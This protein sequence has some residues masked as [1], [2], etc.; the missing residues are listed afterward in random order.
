MRNDPSG[1]VAIELAA[2]MADREPPPPG[3]LLAHMADA[4]EVPAD[5]DPALDALLSVARRALRDA[6]AREGERD[7]AFR[8]L[9]ADAYLTY[10]CEIALESSDPG[11]ALLR[12]AEAVV[13]EAEEE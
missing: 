7:G 6:L 9:A 12:V 10:A 5:A 1:S 4:P 2:W 11:G 8:L 13:A 3:A